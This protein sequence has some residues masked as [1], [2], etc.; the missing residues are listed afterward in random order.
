VCVDPHV[1]LAKNTES[2]VCRLRKLHF[3]VVFHRNFSSQIYFR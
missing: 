2:P 1:Y 3:Y